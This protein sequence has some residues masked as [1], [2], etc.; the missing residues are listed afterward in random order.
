LASTPPVSPR[1]IHARASETTSISASS[2]CT[3]V[4]SE[5]SMSTSEIVHAVM[6]SGVADSDNDLL[7]LDPL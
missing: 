4:T 7:Q 6:I 1:Q 5:P 3:A 2:W